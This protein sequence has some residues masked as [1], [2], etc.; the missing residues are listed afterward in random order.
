MH[1]PGRKLPPDRDVEADSLPKRPRNGIKTAPSLFANLA[2]SFGSVLFIIVLCEISLRALP[3]FERLTARYLQPNPPLCARPDLYQRYDPHGYRLWPS[4]TIRYYYPKDNPRQ[5]ELISNSDGFRS[6]RDFDSTDRRLRIVV[7]GDSFVFGE[8]V[9]ETERFTDVLESMEPSWRVDSLGM[10]GFGPDL[11]LRSLETIGLKVQPDVVLFCMYTD[12]FRRVHPYYAGAGFPIPRFSLQSETLVS[13]PYPM[14][15]V[16]DRLR[17]VA[18]GQDIF[19]RLLGTERRLN[20]AILD[21]FLHLAGNQRFVP[22]II[23][24][25]GN[26]DLTSDKERRGWLR[27]YSAGKTIPFLDL[28]DPILGAGEQAFIPSNWHWNPHGHRLVATEVLRFLAEQV[29]IR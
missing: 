17:L 8:G 22:A 19:W 5:L 26:Q 13:V 1:I 24:I 11:M 9:E 2:L 3:R 23:F 16:W 25:P 18:A 7:V 29:L 20:R 10:T 14:A 28:T 4:R 21:R 27:E 6:R 15:H 12:D